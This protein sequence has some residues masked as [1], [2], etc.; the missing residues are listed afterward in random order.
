MGL[1]FLLTHLCARLLLQSRGSQKGLQYTD[2]GRLSMGPKG[3]YLVDFFLTVAQ[4]G[5]LIGQTY[6]IASNLQN[7]MLEGFGSDIP[8]EWFCKPLKL[9]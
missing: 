7:V 6:F 9:S 3:Q 2:L 4:I 5:F 1:S 8:I